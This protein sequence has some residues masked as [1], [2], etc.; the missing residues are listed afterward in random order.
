MHRLSKTDRLVSCKRSQPNFVNRSVSVISFGNIRCI[1]QYP[2]HLHDRLQRPPALPQTSRSTCPQRGL[3]PRTPRRRWTWYVRCDLPCNPSRP[4]MR[5]RSDHRS[6][7]FSHTPNRPNDHSLCHDHAP[8]GGLPR[9]PS[10]ILCENLAR[11]I[12]A[13]D[14]PGHRSGLGA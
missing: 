2:S 8:R 11:Q 4:A 14:R 9:L 5:R 7:P 6:C 10:R 13:R 1:S 3:R 12:F